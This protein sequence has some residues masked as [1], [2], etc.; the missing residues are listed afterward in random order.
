MK[1][2]VSIDRD[3]GKGKDKSSLNALRKF[4]LEDVV[5]TSP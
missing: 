2:A 3:K 1:T 5:I 4:S